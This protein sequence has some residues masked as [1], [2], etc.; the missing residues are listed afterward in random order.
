[1]HAWGHALTD[2]FLENGAIYCILGYI[3]EYIFACRNTRNINFSYIN[4]DIV[5]ALLLRGVHVYMNFRLFVQ[6]PG[7]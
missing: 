5:A 2:F 4:N 7:L 3:F 6:K 1:M